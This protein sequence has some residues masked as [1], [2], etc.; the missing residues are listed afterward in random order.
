MTEFNSQDFF[1][2]IK[3]L[4]NAYNRNIDKN[5]AEYNDKVIDKIKELY[6]LR[7]ELI[8]KEIYG[9]TDGEI[10]NKIDRHKIISLYIQLFLEN[11]IFKLVS[12]PTKKYPTPKI[13]FINESFCKDFTKNSV[14]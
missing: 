14:Y 11:P 9:D 12:A 6:P 5:F 8:K 3:N 7:L 4:A 13:I 1:T 10:E 2:H